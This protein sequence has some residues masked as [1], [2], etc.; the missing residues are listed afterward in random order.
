[1]NLLKAA[2]LMPL[3]LSL[4]WATTVSARALDVV[5]AEN[6]YAEVA[7]SVGGA[8]VRVD[9]ILNNPNQDPHLFEA[10]PAVARRIA[11]ADV[12]IYNGLG[13]DTWISRLL[14]ASGRD[15]VTIDVGRL[16]GHQQGD[17]PHIWYDPA[18]MP[19]LAGHLA[20]TFTRLDPAHEADY[21]RALDAF[22][23]HLAPLHEAIA[24][25]R[26]RHRGAPV[27]AT[28]PVFTPMAEALGLSMH[29]RGF[30][31]A[32]MNG[33]EPGPSQIIAFE[34]DLREH[35]V[36]AMIY[37]RQVNDPPATRLLR[38][39]REAGIP[40]VAVSEMAPPDTSYVT[41]MTGQLDALEAAL[42]SGKK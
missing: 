39:A 38:I 5:A 10:S 16:T 4:A 15:R 21:A 33:T 30:Q 27:T 6:F 32:I 34:R 35:R 40:T 23:R 37:N 3:L 11:D 29:N 1:M 26:E 24:A 20:E 17:N 18:T 36:R 19:A 25:L 13:Y 2:L 42:D 28:E 9:S 41:W 7:Q 22:K 8:H 31:R 12:V 14:A